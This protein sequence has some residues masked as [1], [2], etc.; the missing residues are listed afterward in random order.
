MRLKHGERILQRV[1]KVMTPAQHVI[2]I[3]LS[4]SDHPDADRIKLAVYQAYSLGQEFGIERAAELVD[5]YSP[6]GRRGIPLM[7]GA[8]ER[9]RALRAL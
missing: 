8:A 3:L 4:F 5:S 6:Q 1:D 7:I 9:I 2:V